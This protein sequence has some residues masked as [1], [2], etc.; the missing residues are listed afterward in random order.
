[1]IEK[2]LAHRLRN[3]LS[4]I[5]KPDDILWVVNEMTVMY[6][7]CRFLKSFDKYIFTMYRV[8]WESLL[9]KEHKKSSSECVY[10]YCPR[11]Q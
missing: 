6:A 4:N 1:M 2:F 10:E 3:C 5:V 9:G 7:G 8:T 11:V